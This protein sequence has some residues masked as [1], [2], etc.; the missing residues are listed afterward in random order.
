MIAF[1]STDFQGSCELLHASEIIDLIQ[2][3]SS[4]WINEKIVTKNALKKKK[5]QASQI[6]LLSKFV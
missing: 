2:K 1:F 4:S 6:K 3:R 5:I